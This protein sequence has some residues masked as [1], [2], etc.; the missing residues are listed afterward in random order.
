MHTGTDISL[1]NLILFIHKDIV[2][3]VE[4]KI[5]SKL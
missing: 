3:N 1:V 4:A 2:T 5:G